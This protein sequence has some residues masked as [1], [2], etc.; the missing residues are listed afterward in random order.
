MAGYSWH[1]F[2]FQ[3]ITKGNC[4]IIDNPQFTQQKE[5]TFESYVIETAHYNFYQKNPGKCRKQSLQPKASHGSVSAGSRQWC[6]PSILMG[7]PFGNGT[8]VRLPYACCHPLRKMVLEFECIYF[9][10][11]YITKNNIIIISHEIVMLRM[12]SF[13]YLP[14]RLYDLIG[15]ILCKQEK[16]SL[17][18]L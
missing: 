14:L 3:P 17:H 7:K 2:S 18:G 12:I 8:F 13:K 6:M 11:K 10:N 16:V 1:F 9:I 15:M 4:A 5:S